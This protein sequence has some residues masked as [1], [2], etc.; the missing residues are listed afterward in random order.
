MGT[1]LHFVV[2]VT[3][4]NTFYFYWTSALRPL[5]TAINSPSKARRA[6][7]KSADLPFAPKQRQANHSGPMCSIDSARD[8]DKNVLLAVQRQKKRHC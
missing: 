4:R 8:K 5:E 7:E 6:S 3:R 1:W 2:S